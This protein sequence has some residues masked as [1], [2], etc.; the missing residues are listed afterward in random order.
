MADTRFRSAFLILLVIAI[1]AAFFAMVRVF[2]LTIVM[3]ALFTGVAYPLYGR[4]VRLFGGRSRL[5]AIATLVVLLVVVIGPLLMVAGA[6]AKQALRVNETIIP[7]LQRMVEEPGELERRLRP[8]PGY[9]LIR[10]YEGRIL[11][12]AGELVGSAGVFV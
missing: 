2:L 1:S 6:V 5:A 11:T 4:V 10:P 12:T 9:D 8:L 7:R 3:A